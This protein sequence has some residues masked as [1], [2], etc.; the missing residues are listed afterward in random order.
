[1]LRLI[2]QHSPPDSSA[3]QLVALLQQGNWLVAELRFEQLSPAV[4]LLRREGAQGSSE[5]LSERAIWSG[6]TE[7]W[8]SGP[9]I[10]AYLRS[11]EPQAPQALLACLDPTS[12][13][14]G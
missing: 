7:P 10:R 9:H 12:F 3:L 11:R 4:V 5:G 14:P 13:G 1:V 2:A 8:R 6:S